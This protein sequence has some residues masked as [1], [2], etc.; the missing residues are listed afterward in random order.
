MPN[1]DWI[2]VRLDRLAKKVCALQT[3]LFTVSI[4]LKEFLETDP[5]D[6]IDSIIYGQQTIEGVSEFLDDLQ[7]EIEQLSEQI[8]EEKDPGNFNLN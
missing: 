1:P 6:D 8:G 7:N 4:S 3:S 5:K 2:N